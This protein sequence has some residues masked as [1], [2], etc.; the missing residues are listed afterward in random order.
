MEHL[1]A[2]TADTMCQAPQCL[3]GYGRLCAVPSPPFWAS[4]T[5][6]RVKPS[7]VLWKTIIF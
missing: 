3:P 4:V 5:K 2:T 6:W 7:S 1:L